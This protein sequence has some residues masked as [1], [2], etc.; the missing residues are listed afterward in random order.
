[1][2]LFIVLLGVYMFGLLPA[3]FVILYRLKR[4]D[5]SWLTLPALAAI[6]VVSVFAGSYYGRGRDFVPIWS[7]SSTRYRDPMSPSARYMPA[8]IAPSSG[9]TPSPWAISPV[10]RHLS[11][12]TSQNGVPSDIGDTSSQVVV[13]EDNNQVDAARLLELVVAECVICADLSRAAPHLSSEITLSSAGAMVGEVKNTGSYHDLRRAPAGVRWLHAGLW[14]PAP[15]ASRTV[16]LPMGRG[17][18]PESG[19]HLVG[20]RQVATLCP[21]SSGAADRRLGAI[22]RRSG[23]SSTGAAELIA[24]GQPIPLNPG[25]STGERFQRYLRSSTGRN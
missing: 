7:A 1:M 15:G 19:R 23:C 12:T 18:Q 2:T 8:L 5:L 16:S 14:R 20:L 22:A 25:E 21:R 4:R 10:S 9:A 13:S 11:T 3:N 17:N 6:L 24:P